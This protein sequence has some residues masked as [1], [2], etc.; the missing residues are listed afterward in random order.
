MTGTSV[1]VTG[2]AGYIGAH[3]CKALSD[4]GYRPVCF[5]NLSTGHA[6]FVRWGPLVNGDLRDTAKLIE[7]LKGEKIAAIMHFAASSL[8]G[9]SVVNPQKYYENNLVGTLSLLEAMRATG[10]A[11]PS[12]RIS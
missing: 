6:D 11:R 2:G 12:K 8:V 9:E 5:D 4:A 7:T 3:A 10:C 1:L